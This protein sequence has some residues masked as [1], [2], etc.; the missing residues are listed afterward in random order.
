MVSSNFEKKAEPYIRRS[1]LSSSI[2]TLS[3]LLLGMFFYGS[4]LSLK[5]CLTDPT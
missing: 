5:L 4:F 2:Q 1:N 3:K